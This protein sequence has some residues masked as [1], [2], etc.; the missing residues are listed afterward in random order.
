MITLIQDQLKFIQC[1]IN[2]VSSESGRNFDNLSIERLDKKNPLANRYTFNFHPLPC[3]KSIEPLIIRVQYIY[4]YCP[5]NVLTL[6][7]I[8]NECLPF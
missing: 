5:N 6:V 2:D 3:E 8:Q 4:D 7:K 1:I